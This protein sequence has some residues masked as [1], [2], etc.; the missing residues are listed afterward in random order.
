[1]GSGKGVVGRSK[2]HPLVKSRR[3]GGKDAHLNFT[4]EHDG[5]SKW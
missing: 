1:M 5:H 2:E 4:D 3:V